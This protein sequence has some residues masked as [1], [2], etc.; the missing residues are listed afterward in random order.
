MFSN[1][2]GGRGVL[3]ESTV[4]E[5]RDTEDKLS[6]DKM[7]HLGSSRTQFL[8]DS[9]SGAKW[10]ARTTDRSLIGEYQLEH[11]LQALASIRCAQLAAN[12]RFE[13]HGDQVR[14]LTPFVE[15]VGLDRVLRARTLSVRES[16]QVASDL[17][18][19]LVSVHAQGVLHREIRPEVIIVKQAVGSSGHLEITS[20]VLTGF[21][22]P[23]ATCGALEDPTLIEDLSYMSPEKTGLYESGLDERTDLYSVGC[24]LYRALTGS[25]A[26]PGKTANEV[27]RK[28]LTGRP[29]EVLLARAGVPLLLSDFV[30]RLA[31]CDP[32]RRYQAAKSAYYDLEEIRRIL[33][34]G[35]EKEVG[36]RLVLGQRDRRHG[37]TE[38]AFI[39]RKE[40]LK[41]IQ[42][43]IDAVES[44]ERSSFVAI[45]S[46][47]GGGKSA[48]LSEIER[49]ARRR[50][51]L[52]FRGRAVTNSATGPLEIFASVVRLAGE[53]AQRDGEFLKLL[54]EKLADHA[55]ALSN[56]APDFS[57][58]LGLT[59][60]HFEGQEEFGEFRMSEAMVALIDA[61]GSGSRPAVFLFDDCQWSQ[62]F[63][64]NVLAEWQSRARTHSSRVF[65]AVSFRTEEVAEQTSLRSIVY[66]ER[67]PLPP[68]NESEVHLLIESMAGDVP[69]EVLSLVNRL[70][71]GSPYMA[72][73]VLRGMVESEALR[74]TEKGEW[75]VDADAWKTLST[76]S[77]AAS[78]LARRL[79]LLSVPTL[80]FLSA[81][82]ILGKDFE[83]ARAARLSEVD[84]ALNCLNEARARH[85]IWMAADS[86]RCLFAH[87]K[88]RESLLDQLTD[89]E[90]KSLHHRAA[91]EIES[92]VPDANLDIAYHYDAAGLPEKA[93][94][95]A[96]A[97]AECALK[98]YSLA[99]AEQQY[100]IAKRG[101]EPSDHSAQ[102]KIALGL[103]R[104]LML[105]G[106]YEG[107]KDCLEDALS[108]AKSDDE[109]AM[110]YSL[111]GS[112]AFKLGD[113]NEAA[114][115]LEHALKLLGKTAPTG[116][117][118]FIALAWQIAIQILHTLFPKLLLGTRGAITGDVV[119]LAEIYKQL[120]YTYWFQRGKYYCLWVHL[121]AMN[122]TEKYAP[123]LSMAQAYSEHG[124]V[125]TMVP[126]F[127]RA[128]RYCERSLA[129]RKQ[130]GDEWGQGQSNNFLGVVYYACGRFRDSLRA[131]QE[132][133]RLLQRTGDRWEASTATWQSGYCYYRLGLLNE[134]VA[135]T[136]AVYEKCVESGD[137]AGA[138]NSAAIWSKAS[139][140]NLPAKVLQDLLAQD[141]DDLHSEGEVSTGEG[142][143]LIRCGRYDEAY[144]LLKSIGQRLKAA[145]VI[146]ELMVPVW[147]WQLT[148]LRL[149][150]ESAPEYAQKQRKVLLRE[151]RK[152]YREAMRLAR[153]FKNNLAH[154]LREGA[155]LALVEGQVRL[156]EKRFELSIANASSREMQ[157]EE[158]LT[159]LLRAEAW[160]LL[161]RAVNPRDETMAREAVRTAGVTIEEILF[162]K[163]GGARTPT[164]ALLDRFSNLLCAGREI[165]AALTEEEVLKTLQNATL[166]LLRGASV[167][168]VSLRDGPLYDDETIVAA[169][170]SQTFQVK[171]EHGRTK[172]A[173]P[174]G[175]HSGV[176][177]LLYV[178]GPESA[179]LGSEESVRLL[180][181]LCGLASTAL[182]NSASFEK[183]QK[184]N[185][186][187]EN[188]IAEQKRVEDE[189]REAKAMADSSSRAKTE[190]L[191]KVSHE[192]RTPLGAILGY[193]ELVLTESTHTDE[194]LEHVESIRRNG[195]SL[196]R[197][198]DD[199]LDV[200]KIEADKMNIEKKHVRF[201]S[202][203][204]HVIELMRAK[205]R[206]KQI[207]IHC[208]L[209]DAPAV[210][211]TDDG[212]VRQI[213]INLLSN[214][215][216]FT[217]EGSVQ[218]KVS[219]CRQGDRLKVETLV[220]DSGIGLSSEQQTRLF[221]PFSQADTSIRS[222][223]GGTGLGLA[224]SRKL[225]RALGG[226]VI[227]KE[228]TL[229]EGSEFYFYFDG[230]S[231][232]E[233]NAHK[234]VAEPPK[235]CPTGQSKPLS[236]RRLLLV[237]DT[238]DNQKMF[239]RFLQGAGAEIAIEGSA[240]DGLRRLEREQFD[241]VLMDIQL[242]AMNGYQ[243]TREIR[244]RGLSIPIL[245]LTA[246]AIAG[247]RERCLSVGFDGFITKPVEK[248]F[249]ISSIIDALADSAP[250][251]QP[252]H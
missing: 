198:I 200:S 14:I 77:Q 141:C 139:F 90:R 250:R 224:V 231:W 99:I 149:R 76:S 187:L 86:S 152:V 60:P 114:P 16:I 89:D 180:K 70:S 144:A 203:V 25:S 104:V 113:M 248:S 63:S 47:S 179:S 150:R 135:I 45:E 197:L 111:I 130:L 2:S 122:L 213:L 234:M 123:S 87:D 175:A 35:L 110:T 54:A 143:R 80:K 137:R 17:L 153:K 185:V 83:Y 121:T 244:R 156:A 124:P 55:A 5:M 229:G 223:F 23:K 67:I 65:M 108:L 242:P 37:L 59:A 173:A 62:E 251:G 204:N 10:V 131:D 93:F 147:C 148:A 247:E 168:V 1:E 40:E 170:T 42:A 74:L 190:F 105:R 69:G 171:N 146:Q 196:I 138:A 95:F 13:M 216:K 73:A 215:V 102:R 174:I 24:V 240:E 162:R 182:E 43:E 128:T 106:D 19:A 15:G 222:K 194:N 3:A 33:E 232:E 9:K 160:R 221:E 107:S 44:G 84:G 192:L 78:F 238:I 68:L 172:L 212:R 245:A 155:M 169:Q 26:F 120:A 27:L 193:S 195:M 158:A 163:P 85:I 225:A 252:A 129:I 58:L 82:A 112:L 51:F 109:R 29:D 219:A 38:P 208:D 209:S 98:T 96:M 71:S 132:A 18:L 72:I 88:I 140:G 41:L 186:A 97:A 79:S 116:I 220:R 199:L 201:Q 189:L 214:A 39:G 22:A 205:A 64:V 142:I 119:A 183:M 136:K 125:L 228:S 53:Y 57:Q 115:P 167:Q 100:R 34:A 235:V 50:E 161:G 49:E 233:L 126:L 11:E 101:V 127:D 151:S 241:L 117:W 226:D 32:R 243:A 181:F 4:L 48:L 166:R 134:A 118:L 188:R 75:K 8:S 66:S 206:E 81:G 61:L 91:L 52:V 92:T 230:G 177:H 227:L 145:S 31:E 94:P 207:E 20:A 218:L 210:V 191:A 46:L 12:I 178:E 157:I 56:F 154:V 184:L 239:K 103:G 21:T 7:E 30:R 6:S 164:V 211:Q 246:H 176:Q 249:L 159:R 202:E 133:I 36:T 28:Q 236:G 217:A 165:S 237:E